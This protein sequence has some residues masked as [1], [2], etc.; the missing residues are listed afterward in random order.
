MKPQRLKCY[1]L[2]TTTTTTVLLLLLFIIH[3]STSSLCTSHAV[4]I[5]K[6]DHLPPFSLRCPKHRNN[7]CTA[8]TAGWNEEIRLCGYTWMLKAPE[9]CHLQLNAARTSVECVGK[10]LKTNQF[11]NL[12]STMLD[13]R[14]I[15][16]RCGC[17]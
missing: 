14:T 15:Q 1:T 11:C 5:H 6:M 13:D 2:S 12:V 16:Y 9:G 7:P 10:C 17:S 3:T 8:V 4:A